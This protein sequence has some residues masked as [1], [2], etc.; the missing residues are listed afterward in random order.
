MFG[1]DLTGLDFVWPGP[2]ISLKGNAMHAVLPPALHFFQ[3]I[4]FY[5]ITITLLR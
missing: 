2:V 3:L 5:Y 1:S 4:Y